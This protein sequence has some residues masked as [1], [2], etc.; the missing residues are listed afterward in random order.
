MQKYNLF[1]GEN[2]HSSF[3]IL[4]NKRLVSREW[5]TY[6]EIMA[7]YLGP[8]S[9]IDLSRGVSNCE[10]YRELLKTFLEIRKIIE[11]RLGVGCIE[12][13]G[14]NRDKQF[15]YIGIDDDPLADLRNA[16]AINN[17]R[18]YWKFCQDSAGFFPQSWLDYYFQDCIDLIKIKERQKRGEQVIS[19]SLDR[20]HKNIE[21]LPF[22]Y[23]SILFILN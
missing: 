23:E 19:A 20:I 9:E 22:L 18:Q 1:F 2:Y 13:S 4:I 3:A 10:G 21:F 7:E 11:D 16:R 14:S 5:F 12:E 6:T 8:K 17:L 15:R